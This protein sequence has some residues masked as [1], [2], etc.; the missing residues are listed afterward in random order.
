MLKTFINS[1]NKIVCER[2]YLWFSV[3]FCCKAENVIAFDVDSSQLFLIVEFDLIATPDILTLRLIAVPK[4][5]HRQKRT[6][7]GV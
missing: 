4:W 7:T 6:F 5:R 3:T 2:I 1:I